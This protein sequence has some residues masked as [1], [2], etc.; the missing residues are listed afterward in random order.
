MVEA[1]TLF[2]T[3]KMLLDGY[4]KVQDVMTKTKQHWS[5][6]AH[7]IL[8]AIAANKILSNRTIRKSKLNK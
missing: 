5:N 3:K 7:K 8:S 4:V 1:M 2:D 6:L